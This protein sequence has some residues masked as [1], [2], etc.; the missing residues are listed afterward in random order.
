[1]HVIT[2]NNHII[3]VIIAINSSVIDPKYNDYAV[4][5][6]SMAGLNLANLAKLDSPKTSLMFLHTH[7]SG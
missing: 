4:K 2:Y 1:M 3:S 5:D 7:N 6:E